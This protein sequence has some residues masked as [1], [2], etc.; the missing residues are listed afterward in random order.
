MSARLAAVALALGLAAC[1]AGPAPITATPAPTHEAG[2]LN[3]TALLDLSGDRTPNG[4]SQR[5]AL[6]LWLDQQGTRTPQVRVRFIDVAGSEAR[7]ILELKRA[8]TEGRA[9]A[10]IVGVPVDYDAAFARIVEL[11]GLPVLFTLPI[12]DP[13]TLAGG[14]WAFAL[15][16]TPAQLA[17]AAVDDATRRGVLVPSLIVSDESGPAVAE[18]V[19]LQAELA[20]RGL[21]VPLAKV[22]AA[23]VAPRLAGPLMAARSVFFAGAVPAYA[24]AARPAIGSPS[25]PLLYFSYLVEPAALGELREAA[26]LATWPGSRRTL[27]PPP[28]AP[29]ARA[30]F[31]RGYADR[32]GPPGTHA[33]VAYDAVSMLS[34]FAGTGVDAAVIRNTLE[35]APFA[36]VATTFTFAPVRH[37]G[38]ATGD[39]VYLRWTAERSF[40]ML[41]PDPRVEHQPGFTP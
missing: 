19:A 1:T 34:G 23:D 16:P 27:A 31:V 24:A 3:V 35:A 29:P 21:G 26:A 39:L 28:D 30:A 13:A 5:D 40:P 10:V 7:T 14:R 9:D 17:K 41:A 20:K 11:A 37:A 6:Q 2:A 4:G 12:P 18:R 22:T 38:F 8:A 32:Y 15:A 25:G 36:G 33:A